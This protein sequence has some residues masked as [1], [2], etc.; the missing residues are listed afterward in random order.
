[1]PPDPPDG[2]EPKPLGPQVTLRLAWLPAALASA[3]AAA[4][5]WVVGARVAAGPAQGHHPWAMLLPASTVLALLAACLAAYG[6]RWQ[7]PARLTVLWWLPAC[8]ALTC[9]AAIPTLG[10]A[11]EPANLV[12]C[13]SNMRQILL[14]AVLYDEQFGAWPGDVG[15]LLRTQELTDAVT[16]CPSGPAGPSTTDYALADARRPT[17]EDE[18]VLFESFTRHVGRAG[19]GDGVNVGCVDGRVEFVPSAEARR[20]V[21]TAV[22]EG[23][24]TVEQAERV[25]ADEHPVE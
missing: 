23:R 10:R 24:L 14:A 15:D 19:V 3:S 5:A 18:A 11:R 2:N 8:A 7:T 21:L 17:G 1:M 9:V 6:H 4:S 12:K 25:L 20:L 13:A 16:W 22:A